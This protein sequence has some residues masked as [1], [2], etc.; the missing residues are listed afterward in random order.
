VERRLDE[1][2]AA[3]AALARSTA[4]TLD[5]TAILTRAVGALEPV[6]ALGSVSLWRETRQ[7]TELV[8][9][10]AHPTGGADPAGFA[11]AQAEAGAVTLAVEA[12]GE[13]I[14]HLVV[15]PATDEALTPDD[16][17]LLDIAVSQ[18]S[19]ALERVQL[20]T[21]V[22]E[23]ERLKSDFI[24]RVSHELRTP[25]TIITGFLETLIAH[26][27]KLDADQRMHMLERSRSASSRLS[28]LIEE[29][30]ILSRLEGGVVS[31]QPELLAMADVLEAVRSGAAAPE[32]VVA[33]G[34]LDHPV[35]TDRAL[36][37][38][39]L[40]LLVDNAIKYGDVAEL[41][42][43]LDDGHW[44][45][46]VR[47]RGPGFAEDIRATAFEM[48]AR[49]ASTN[50]V[51]GLGVGLSIARTLVEVLDGSIAIEDAEPGPGAVVRV[52]LPA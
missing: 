19:G 18:I 42:T 37:V 48:F 12:R 6:L 29:L 50:A 9:H 47:D 34:P 17:A 31:P 3:V 36:L 24:A 11:E 52:S 33:A 14:G 25:I 5:P 51:P 10:V 23:L 32:Q 16:R 21:E 8:A 7:G 1:V 43:T 22:M 28:R 41:T 26:D 45:I 38:R 46:E 15:R 4:T 39:V 20:F 40:G 30:L 49:S 2:A 27:A 35:V 13:R 44:V